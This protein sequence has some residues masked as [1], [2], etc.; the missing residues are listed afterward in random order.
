M[1]TSQN[2]EQLRLKARLYFLDDRWRRGWMGSVL[3]K[4]K[5]L[6]CLQ[7]VRQSF[8]PLPNLHTAGELFRECS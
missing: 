8:E 4:I 1:G 6:S 3:L 2:V 7:E 5:I